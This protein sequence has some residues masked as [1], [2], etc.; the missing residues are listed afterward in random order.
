VEAFL[1]RRLGFMDIPRAIEAA[2]ED[3]AAADR[4]AAPASIGEVLALDQE[5]RARAT[6]WCQERG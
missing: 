2:L 3:M 5:A 6:R 4:L 1:D